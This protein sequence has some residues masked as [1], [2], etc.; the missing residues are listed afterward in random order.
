MVDKC[1]KSLVDRQPGVF[2][3]NIKAQ[4]K[5]SKTYQIIVRQTLQ[6][7]HL[8]NFHSPVLK[9]LQTLLQCFIVDCFISQ[10]KMDNNTGLGQETVY[11]R[12]W[13][14]LLNSWGSDNVLHCTIYGLFDLNEQV[15]FRQGPLFNTMLS[16]Q[17][18]LVKMNL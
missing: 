17:H 4:L 18:D 12:L 1:I 16:N 7:Y 3:V 5:R 2:C 15:H 14:E 10:I 9:V 11:F 8:L 6:D 13:R